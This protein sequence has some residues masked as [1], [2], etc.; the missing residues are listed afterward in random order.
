MPGLEIVVVLL[1][2]VLSL[3]WPARR[4]GVSGPVLLL[5]GGCLIGL[6]PEFRSVELPPEVVLLVFLPPLLYTEA[7][8]ISPHQIRANLRTIA[9][10]AVGLIP[11]TARSSAPAGSAHG[12]GCRCGAPPGAGDPGRGGGT[13]R[14]AG[15]G[16]RARPLLEPGPAAP[17][18]W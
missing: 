16:H 7:L 17:P 1:T 3:S 6:L 12:S 5:L 18:V 14:S 13:A 4:L 10:L 15:S 2:A 9:L 11:A 8:T